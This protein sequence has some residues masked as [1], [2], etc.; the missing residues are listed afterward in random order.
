VVRGVDHEADTI[1]VYFALVGVQ[2]GDRL[3]QRTDR[4]VERAADAR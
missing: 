1:G 2:G 3:V 4:P